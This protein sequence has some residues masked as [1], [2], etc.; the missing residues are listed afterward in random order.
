MINEICCEACRAQ[1][2]EITARDNPELYGAKQEV[3]IIEKQLEKLR[4]A[5]DGATTAGDRQE[6]RRIEY[7]I[8]KACREL[9]RLKSEIA[10]LRLTHLQSKEAIFTELLNITRA[11]ITIARRRIEPLP[12]EPYAMPQLQAVAA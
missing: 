6:V 10:S 4:I 5:Y 2:F 12:I 3:T 9:G 1:T 7:S 11:E 8:E